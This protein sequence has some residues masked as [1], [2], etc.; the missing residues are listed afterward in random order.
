[1]KAKNELE[2]FNG[3]KHY[4]EQKS[5]RLAEL[6]RL[7]HLTMDKLLDEQEEEL[8]GVF[9]SAELVMGQIDELDQEYLE[10]KTYFKQGNISAEKLPQ[11]TQARELEGTIQRQIKAIQ[12]KDQETTKLM[13]Q[14]RA[15]LLQG[16]QKINAG[17][18]VRNAYDG[19][20]TIGEGVYVDE[21][22]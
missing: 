4:L 15:E 22:N 21:H 7:S 19:N 18:K 9:T 16:M 2:M 8:G 10:Y 17:K 13:H 11:L 6:D 3:Y 14:R 5:R 12:A 20:Y 1:M